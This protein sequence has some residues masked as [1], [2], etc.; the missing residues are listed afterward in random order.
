VSD[1]YIGEI[2]MF[3]ITKL[4]SNW[5]ACDGSI[6][7]I[8]SYPQLYGLI[9]TA[10]GGDGQT[11]FGL[12]DMRSRAPIHMGQAHGLSNYPLAQGGGQEV[13]TL[14]TE[15]L[16]PHNHGF[17][18]FDDDGSTDTPDNQT[19]IGNPLYGVM[20]LNPGVGSPQVL[21]SRAIDFTGGGQPHENCMTTCP[22]AFAIAAAGTP[23]G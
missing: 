3:A 13:V 14:A 8:G 1:Y 6:V 20:F 9:G 12:P 10:Y 15:N 18:V 17:T 2:R 19:V 11:T 7:P 21:D 5:L 16:A 4:P 23:P 22:I